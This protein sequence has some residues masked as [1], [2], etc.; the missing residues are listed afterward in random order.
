[1]SVF[2]Y[3]A[4]PL[5][6]L[7]VHLFVPGERSRRGNGRAWRSPSPASSSR[8]ATASFRRAA[9]RARRSFGLIAAAL[10]ARRR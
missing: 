6:A 2:V 9:R 4:P 5:T 1:M 8:S 3:L 10:W 7:G